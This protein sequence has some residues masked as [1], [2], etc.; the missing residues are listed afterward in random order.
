MALPQEDIDAIMAA[1]RRPEV[2]LVEYEGMFGGNP[3]LAEPFNQG[4]DQRFPSLFGRTDKFVGANIANERYKDLDE[5]SAKRDDRATTTV[6][7]FE[8]PSKSPKKGLL[9][10]LLNKYRNSEQ[11]ALQGKHRE[12]ALA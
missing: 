4:R 7:Q 6:N 8:C 3:S 11:K 10:K 5:R 9:Q 12:L 2:P 1:A